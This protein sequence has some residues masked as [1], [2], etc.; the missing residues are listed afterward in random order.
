MIIS[1][2]NI[3]SIII[4]MINITIVNNKELKY[5]ENLKKIYT[6]MELTN[7]PRNTYWS[8]NKILLS[9]VG[10]LLLILA[11]VNVVWAL[12]F[13]VFVEENE[14]Q[15]DVNLVKFLDIH[16]MITIIGNIPV[17]FL[18]FTNFL[19]KLVCILMSLS[20][21]RAMVACSIMAEKAF[22]KSKVVTNRLT[23]QKKVM[24]NT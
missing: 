21:P 16:T 14:E 20:C 5:Y 8:K 17:G 11:C 19:I 24:H 22:C 7:L 15:C 1:M 23:F 2:R 18:F 3:K 13:K 4:F 10:I 6:N 12:Y 9:P